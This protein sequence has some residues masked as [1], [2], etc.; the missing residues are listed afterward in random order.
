MPSG[1]CGSNYQDAM[2]AAQKNCIENINFIYQ[3]LY[4][5][6]KLREVIQ[7]SCAIPGASENLL[8]STCDN[9]VDD[10][11]FFAVWKKQVCRYKKEIVFTKNLIWSKWYECVD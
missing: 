6:S 4:E 5:K 8:E 11:E 7:N 9:F 10:R 2:F 3:K 1:G